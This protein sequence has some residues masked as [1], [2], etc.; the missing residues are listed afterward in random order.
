MSDDG[1]GFSLLVL[2]VGSSYS[3]SVAAALYREWGAA[4]FAIPLLTVLAV[5]T[6][7]E[8]STWWQRDVK[9]N[10]IGAAILAAATFPVLLASTPLAPALGWPHGT[11]QTPPHL[12]PQNDGSLTRL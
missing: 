3:S 9:G 7:G 4:R 5:G 11:A 12:L 1:V 2:W 10:M 8:A 6:V